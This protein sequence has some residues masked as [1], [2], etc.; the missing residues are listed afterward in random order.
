MFHYKTLLNPSEFSR[1][2]Q[3]EY[4]SLALYASHMV[5]SIRM[6]FFGVRRKKTRMSGKLFASGAPPRKGLGFRGL[7]T[8]EGAAAAPRSGGP[9]QFSAVSARRPPRGLLSLRRAAETK[10][11]EAEAQEGETRGPPPPQSAGHEPKADEAR[12]DIGE[13]RVAR[14]SFSGARGGL[15]QIGA[16]GKGGGGASCACKASHLR[17]SF[18]GAFSA[19]SWQGKAPQSV[20]DRDRLFSLTFSLVVS[21]RHTETASPIII[22]SARMQQA[23][24]PSWLGASS[25]RTGVSPTITSGVGGRSR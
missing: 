16:P 13:G 1:Y 10:R 21:L 14:L 5:S 2:E 20:A 6:R 23:R 19:A 22:L 8:L 25:Q 24:T 18:L 7:G 9:E 12:S 11:D 17:L 4:G 3:H 15:C